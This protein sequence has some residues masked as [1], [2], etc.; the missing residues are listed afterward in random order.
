[1]SEPATAAANWRLPAPE[2]IPSTCIAGSTTYVPATGTGLPSPFACLS[3]TPT[4]LSATGAPISAT[5][6]AMGSF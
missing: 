3:I 6:F 2:P 5:A 1:M 4:D